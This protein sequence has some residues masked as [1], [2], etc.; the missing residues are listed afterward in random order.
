MLLYSRML[1]RDKLEGYETL[2]PQLRNWQGSKDYM[3]TKAFFLT[4]PYQWMQIILN[5]SSCSRFWF[6]FIATVVS[7]LAQIPLS[8]CVFFWFVIEPSKGNEVLGPTVGFHHISALLLP[9]P[10]TSTSSQT[11]LSGSSFTWSFLPYFR[12]FL[13]FGSMVIGPSALPR[14]FAIFKGTECFQMFSSD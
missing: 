7:W 2:W 8:S 9:F 11:K 6:V 1:F 12:I 4:K 13:P 14:V 5:F 10:A 3:K